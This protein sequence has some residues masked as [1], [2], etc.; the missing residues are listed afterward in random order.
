MT[1]RCGSCGADSPDDAVFCESCGLKLASPAADVV[2][3]VACP[4]CGTANPPESKFC[5]GCGKQ[6]PAGAEPGGRKPGFL[7]TL[8]KAG[9]G[10]AALGAGGMAIGA[11]L[12]GG[13]AEAADAAASAATAGGATPPGATPG[14]PSASAPG[15]GTPGA[16]TP[17]APGGGT[18]GAP[19]SGPFGGGT[20]G[21][22]TPGAP[23]GGTPGSPT[24]GPFGGGTPGSPTPGAPTGTPPAGT[25][26]AGTPPAGTPPAGTPPGALG[27][28]PGIAAGGL[29]L[30]TIIKVIVIVITGLIGVTVGAG[31]IGGILVFT[32]NPQPCADREIPVSPGAAQ[33]LDDKWDVFSDQ[34]AAGPGFVTYT[35]TEVT[36]RGVRYLD[37]ND[38]PLDNLQVYL[39]PQ[40]YGE[41]T[42]TMSVA[43]I[44]ANVLIRGTL[45]LSGD[46]PQLDIESV[47][48]GNL[49][50]AVAT[51]LVNQILDRGGV[52]TIDVDENLT[53]IDIGDGEVTLGGGP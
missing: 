28:A 18:P 44:D 45:D 31:I 14:A 5:E 50:G 16:P 12:E 52:K 33:A 40:G 53:S 48:A 3:T 8:G 37:D 2:P 27:P 22:P 46:Q 29:T 24:S 39:C 15:G 26:P 38:V 7:G 42:G 35:E 9:A 34:I 49:P 13:G 36:S 47:E 30:G 41:A 51:R 19:T 43:G 32:G 10:G 6:I 21:A 25:P 11:T 4:S 17:G 23:G 1:V 20:P